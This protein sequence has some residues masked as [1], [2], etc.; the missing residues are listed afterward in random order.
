MSTPTTAQEHS[1]E[2][3]VCN[4]G[5][6]VGPPDTVNPEFQLTKVDDS[7]MFRLR[8]IGNNAVVAE[9][10][11]VP[12]ETQ[13][14]LEVSIEEEVKSPKILGIVIRSALK[15][16]EQG[17]EVRLVADAPIV[18]RAAYRAGFGT[19]SDAPQNVPDIDKLD[20]EHTRTMQIT[21]A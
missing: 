14:T 7:D 1:P 19:A 18:A 5:H 2:V 15:K 9:V 17:T 8:Q 13:T 21:A 3:F 20:K 10:A 16:V 4:I 12:H 11:V 6:K